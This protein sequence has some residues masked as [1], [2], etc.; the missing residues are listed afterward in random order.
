GDAQIDPDIAE[1]GAP[2]IP[3]LAQ[4]PAAALGPRTVPQRIAGLKKE[5]QGLRE[6]LG[7]QRE[8]LGSMSRD[9]A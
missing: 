1:E 8:V 9:F 5:V 2:A 4:A 3:A 6:S 7:E